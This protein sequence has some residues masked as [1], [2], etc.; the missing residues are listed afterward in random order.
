MTLA[1]RVAMCVAAC[2]AASPAASPAQLVAEGRFG[3]VGLGTMGYHMAGHLVSAGKKIKVWNRSGAR[4]QS[5]AKAFS[6]EAVAE[7]EGFA[8]CG[9]VFTC[10][11]TSAEV[12]AV[13]DSLASVLRPGAILVDCTSGEPSAT[14]EIAA[15]LGARGIRVVDCPVSGGPAGAEAG[16]LTTML[17]GADDD[18]AAVLPL[19]ASTFSK[20]AVHV[21]PIGSGHAVKAINNALNTA[22]VL[23]G[24]E[25]LLALRK[26]GVPADARSR[27]QL[28]VGALARDG[29][30]AAGGGA[31]RPLRLRLQAAAHGEGHAD[32]ARPAERALPRGDAAPRGRAHRTPPSI[33][34]GP[35]RGLFGGRRR[36]RSARARTCALTKRPSEE[37]P[38]R[39]PLGRR[40]PRRKTDH[41]RAIEVERQRARTARLA[42]AGS[43]GRRARTLV[44][45]RGSGGGFF[46]PALTRA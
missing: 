33:R 5:H 6:T 7:F 16:T 29:R 10:L 35:G 42:S 19:V 14:V 21:G 18:V 28:V 37:A 2:C 3:F 8:D 43:L 25:G 23:L 11:P 46:R 34:V 13:A 1:M 17:G 45:V 39:G 12:A 22:H 41:R 26:F 44:R 36:S 9:V 32:R 15:R 27:H 31:H 24:A 4:A 20:K 38:A 40:A 30:A